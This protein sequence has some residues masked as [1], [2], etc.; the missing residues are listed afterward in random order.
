MD[1]AH[2]VAGL[3]EDL[4]EARRLV[5]REHDP[6]ALAHPVLDAVEQPRGQPGRQHRLAPAELVAAGEAL[7]GEGH[8][9]GRAGLGLPGELQRPA[10]RAGAPS[11]RA[12]AGR[13]TASPWAGRRPRPSPRAAPRPVATGSRRHRRGR[14]AR[15]GRAGTMGR[16]GR[17]PSWGR[18]GAPRPRRHRRRGA[19]GLRA[20][21]APVAA[22]PA[23]RSRSSGQPLREAAA[24]PAEPLPDLVGA[25]GRQQ[26][27]GRG[28]EGDLSHGLDAALVGG[29]EGAQGVDLVAEQ[30]DPDGQR[31]RR[32]EDVDDAAPAREL[33]AAGDLDH[34]RVAALVELGDERLHADAGAGRSVRISVG[35]SS[36]AI[37]AWTSAWTLATSTFAAPERQAARAATRAAVSSGTSSLRS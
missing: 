25:A 29:V 23:K 6:G 28:Q 4:R 34:R 7:R 37:V 5:A 18:R 1:D 16:G 36:G 26:E 8:A 35:R 2:G 30:L 17:G 9:V 10:R 11:S 15:R 14:R 27:L 3:G 32:R 31:R 33:A 24:D 20:T 13:R 19:R 12:A 21:L 22:S